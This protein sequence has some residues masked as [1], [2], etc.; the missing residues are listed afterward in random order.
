M[1]LSP[2]PLA[3]IVA[4]RKKRKRDREARPQESKAIRGACDC[5]ALAAFI[6]IFCGNVDR[7]MDPLLFQ[8]GDRSIENLYGMWKEPHDTIQILGDGVLPS[9]Q[10]K[11]SGSLRKNPDALRA[12][13][14]WPNPA[15]Q[16]AAIRIQR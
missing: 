13:K 7:G 8:Q 12:I 2:V 4:P 9:T 1:G 6:C 14:A 16:A 11:A 10:R 3:V 15:F 5:V